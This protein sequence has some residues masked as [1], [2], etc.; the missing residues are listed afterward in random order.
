MKSLL[1]ILLTAL[2]TDG[3]YLMQNVGT[4]QYLCKD[5]SLTTNVS[6]AADWR[7]VGWEDSLSGQFQTHIY[8]DEIVLAL[9]NYGFTG[10]QTTMSGKNNTTDFVENADGSYKLKYRFGT[11]TRYLNVENDGSRLSAAKTQS[12]YNDWRFIPSGRRHSYR[13]LAFSREGG[14]SCYSLGYRSHNV[15]GEERWLSGWV[16]FPTNG[17]GGTCKATHQLMNC[18]ETICSNGEAPS[19][20]GPYSALLSSVMSDMPVWMA[21]D[22][23]GFGK[24]LGEDHPYVAPDIMA[25]TCVDM[26]LAVYDMLYD[27]HGLDMYEAKL[28]TYGAG[29]SQGGGVILAIQKYVETSPNLTAAQREAINYVSTCCGAGP[30]NT[31]ATI[32]QYLYDNTIAMP[33]AAPLLVSGM[34]AAYPEIFGEYRAEDYFSDAFNNANI[35]GNMRACEKNID[36]M[37][38]LINSACGGNGTM[39]SMLSDSAKNFNSD[40]SQ[41][42][43]WALGESDLTRDWVPQAKIWMYHSSGDDVVPYLNSVSAYNRFLEAGMPADRITLET[44][45]GLAHTAGAVAFNAMMITGGYRK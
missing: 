16:K 28:P 20:M 19:V 9:R 38:S 6:D 31:L 25:E 18:H 12:A 27:M 43:L 29:Y 24:S 30:Y 3:S 17:E 1:L 11:D 15:Q 34:V 10:W 4:G 2:L 36:A 26:M 39:W 13:I 41:R 8:C 7:L 40:L 44:A 35:L 23:L 22:Y 42:L 5:G 14:F 32:S 33:V 21:P 37:N 45:S